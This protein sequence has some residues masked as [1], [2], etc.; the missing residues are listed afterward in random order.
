MGLAAFC[1]FAHR[2][3]DALPRGVLFDRGRC[4]AARLILGCRFGWQE[5]L[6]VRED[7][8]GPRSVELVAPLRGLAKVASELKVGGHAA[9]WDTRRAGDA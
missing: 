3:M 8:L 4:L 7:V 9:C 1:G 2:A 6:A 5:S